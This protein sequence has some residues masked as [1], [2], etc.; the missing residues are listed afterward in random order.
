MPAEDSHNKP[1]E[2]ILQS[3]DVIR[4]SSLSLTDPL[5]SVVPCSL[6]LEHVNYNTHI[7]QKNDTE[8]FVPSTSEFEVD[9]F[10]RILDKNVNFGCSDEKI[11]SVLDGKDI[12]ITEMK[13]VEQITGKLT[14]AEHTCLKTYS[15]ILPNQDLNLNYNLAEHPTNQSMGS[16]ASLGT[17]ISESPYAS[18][19]A[20]G[21]KN[22]ENNQHLVYHKS[23][24]EIKDNKSDD[25]LKAAGASDISAEPTQGRKSP[26]ILNHRL[27]R[28]LLGPMNVANDISIEKNMKQHVVPETIVQNQ[29][30]NNLNKL[31]VECNKFHSGHV[32]VRKQVHFSEKVE[33]LHPKR[34]LSKLE[35][36][37]KRCSSVRAKRRWVSKSLT[38]FVP[39]VKHSLTN[40]YKNVVNEFIFQGIEFLLTGLSSQKEKDME[41]LIRNSGGVVLHDIPSPRNSGSKR[42]STLSHF[43]I[44]LCMRKLQ[45]TKFL[46]GCAVG[47][48][49][50]KVD[51]LTDCLASGKILQ[52][53]KYMVLPNRKDMK[54]TRIGTTIHQRNQKHIFER[55]G[56]LLH[57][58]HSFC[59][60]LACIIKHGGGQVFKTLQWLVRSSDEERTLVGTIVVEDKATISRHLKHCAKERNIPMMPSSWIIKS[61]YSG[62]LLP[63]TEEKNTL[64]LPFIKVSEVPSSSDMSEEI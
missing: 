27:R 36:S 52:P 19:H 63:L 55:V 37:H 22:E 46:Y 32:R 9:N 8:D 45:T 61:L 10:Q 43:P 58:K 17:M 21:N 7:D 64:S 39:C 14:R 44:I 11:M 28:C 30:N 5:C 38:T 31:Q 53:E 35:S 62:K 25:E 49:I 13:M 26:L 50:L 40:Y 41:A 6:P 47:A 16:S 23:I 60:K 24:I 20:D 15:M 57:G 1:D 42:N 33:E 56:I 29:Q 51:W 2:S 18:K 4:C 34:K 48:S 54:W 59:T 12:P 3:Q